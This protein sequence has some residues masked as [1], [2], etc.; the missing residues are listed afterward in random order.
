MKFLLDADMPK[1]TADII[2]SFGYDVEDV[3]DI[4]LGAA[5]DKE[6]IEY[7]LKNE[8]IIVTRDTDFGE[9]LRYP[10]HPGAI[11]F[12]LPYTFIAEKI[13]ERVKKFFETVDEKDI[14]NTIIIV[15]LARY[16]RRPL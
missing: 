1:S 2:R 10:K 13:N 14:K 4:G 15:E 11:I 8:R 6:I 3:R 7:A 5:K 9:V 12:R 16:R